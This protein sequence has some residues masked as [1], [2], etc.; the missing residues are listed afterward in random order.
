MPKRKRE[1]NS[2]SENE[3]SKVTAAIEKITSNSDVSKDDL[4]AYFEYQNTSN[5]NNE[6]L[7]STFLANHSLVHLLLKVVTTMSLP[8]MTIVTGNKSH[9]RKMVK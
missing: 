4:Q 6:E 5:A 2:D 1:S 7:F 3:F 9:L 8:M